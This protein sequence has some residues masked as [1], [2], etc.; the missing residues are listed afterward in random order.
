MNEFLNQRFR[1]EADWPVF[2]FLLDFLILFKM[3]EYHII[4]CLF[5]DTEVNLL[6]NVFFSHFNKNGDSDLTTNICLTTS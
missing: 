2:L 4:I 5:S 3:W 6:R 1:T